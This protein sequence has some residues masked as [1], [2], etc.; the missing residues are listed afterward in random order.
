MSKCS[1][2]G[3]EFNGKGM[4]GHVAAVHSLERKINAQIT[5]AKK[6][7]LFLKTCPKCGKKFEVK[8]INRNGEYV[9]LR[10]EREYDSRSCANGHE[11]SEQWNKNISNGLGGRKPKPPKILEPKKVK[12]KEIC[13][14][15]SKQLGKRNA[16]HYCKICILKQ[17][18]I[19]YDIGKKISQK[20]RAL[21]YRRKCKST[22]YYNGFR[23][24]SKWEVSVA[25]ILDKN[26]I[27]WIQPKPLKWVD[28]IGKDHNYFSDFYL[29]D[30]DIYLDPKND[31]CIKAQEEKLNYIN[32]HYPNVHILNE[33]KIN[34]VY[35]LSLLAP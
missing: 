4:G 5:R 14:T 26:K 17:P 32:N 13:K 25:K 24:D 7:N 10:N 19:M 23:F 33:Q 20:V 12:I 21:T 28:K 29:T 35:I 8:R 31:Y 1:I 2:C 11:H 27:G 6:Y 34:E 3:K 16:N 9:A 18:I 15:C 30:Y 22:V